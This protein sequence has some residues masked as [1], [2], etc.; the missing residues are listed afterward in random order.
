MLKKVTLV[1]CLYIV[2]AVT[3][4]LYNLGFKGG[5]IFDDFP[6]LQDLGV[7]GTI[8]S[9]EKARAFIGNGFSGPTGRPISL[10][11]FLINDNTWPSVAYGFKQTNTYIHLI[12]GLL[13]FWATLLIL[14]SYKIDQK[15]IYWVTFLSTSIWLLHPYFVSTTLYV[16]QRMAQLATLFSL[17]G[18]VGYFKGR[19]LLKT[20]PLMGYII[21]TLSIGLSTILATYSKENGALLPLLILIL[22]FCHPK[23]DF[24]KPIWQ[25]RLVCLWLPSLIIGFLLAKYIDFSENPWPNRNFNQIE[26]LYSESRIVVEYLWNLIVPEVEGR[27]LYQDGYIKSASIL[28]P[29]TTL[30]SLLFLLF[31]TIIAFLIKN[32]FS[33]LAVAILFYLAAHLMESTFIG[34]ELYF[35]H[36]NYLAALFLFL[37]IAYGII[38]LGDIVNK[39]IVIVASLAFLVVLSFLTYQRS[40]LWS[41]TDYL[42]LFW[43]KNSPN[44]ARAQ[45]ALANYLF[46]EGLYE[47]SNAH[48]ETAIQKLPNSSLLVIRLLSQKVYLRQATHADFIHAANDISVKPFD[49]QTVM[50]LRVLVEFIVENNLAQSYGPDMQILLKIVE[51]SKNYRE[52]SVFNRLIPYLNAKLSLALNQDEIALGY[53]SEAIHRYK[54]V[55]AGLMMVAEMASVGKFDLALEMLQEVK[56]EYAKQ[57]VK[58]LR[59][60]STEYSYEIQRLEKYLNLKIGE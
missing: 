11:S 34:L 6:N 10:A 43:A 40:K 20:K 24:V 44:S 60:S 30:Y 58:T 2:L 19:L 32:R 15:K 27:G 49:A 39:K 23:N 29:I 55:E 41:D 45:N 25:W 51:N 12:N 31:I 7:Y 57:N 46:D 8:D 47:E 22:E 59:R 1:L 38:S 4:C 18:V 33:L 26:R 42:Q 56:V 28:S 9:L 3:Y 53:Y 35:E 14:T 36:R 13:L 50:G 5:F 21:M 17:I 16:V 54:D 37:P 48:L 52:F